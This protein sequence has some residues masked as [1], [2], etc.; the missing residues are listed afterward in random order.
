MVFCILVK[1]GFY[2]KGVGLSVKNCWVGGGG[3][4]GVY[5]EI[6]CFIRLCYFI[7]KNDFKLKIYVCYIV[8]N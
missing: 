6:I 7:E 8:V 2:F 4:G 1:V 3:D 5:N